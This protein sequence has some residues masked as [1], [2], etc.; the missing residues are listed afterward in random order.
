M[1]KRTQVSYASGLSI[2]VSLSLIV[3]MKYAG[4]FESAVDGCKD[5]ESLL[6]TEGSSLNIQ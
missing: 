1:L 3:L 4:M 5:S 6:D 2:F